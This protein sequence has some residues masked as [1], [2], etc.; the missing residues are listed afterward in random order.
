MIRER[1]SDA[2]GCVLHRLISAIEA[3]ETF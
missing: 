3:I 2:S 1:F